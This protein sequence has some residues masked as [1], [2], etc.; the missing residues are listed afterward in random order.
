MPMLLRQTDL[1]MMTISECLASK[2]LKTHEVFERIF[3]TMK[4]GLKDTLIFGFT[5]EIFNPNHDLRRRRKASLKTGFPACISATCNIYTIFILQWLVSTQVKVMNIKLDL[6][7]T[8]CFM[9]Q[10][11][12][13]WIIRHLAEEIQKIT[14]WLIE[15]LALDK[16]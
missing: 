5:T 10:S 3:Y 12:S 16:F 8:R 2:M 13:L 7:P 1:Q 15:S 11:M 14:I 9:G 4:P 6:K